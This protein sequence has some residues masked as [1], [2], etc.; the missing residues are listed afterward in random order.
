MYRLLTETNRRLEKCMSESQNQRQAS[1]ESKFD[2]GFGANPHPSF[3]RQQPDFRPPRMKH[4][5]AF[6]VL[7]E[8][9]ESFAREAHYMF[10]TEAHKTIAFGKRSCPGT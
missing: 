10:K 5:Q 7:E 4:F 3:M 6:R 9:E 2:P 1:R 8:T